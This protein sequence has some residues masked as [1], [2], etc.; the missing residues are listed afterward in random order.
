V[1]R[2]VQHG[3]DPNV[4][5]PKTGRTA[6]HR[7]V[8]KEFDPAQL[9]WLIANGASA[10]IRDRDGVTARARAARKRDR[11]W[12]DALAGSDSRDRTLRSRDGVA[13]RSRPRPTTPC[14]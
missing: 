2:L 4:Q 13:G 14:L 6:L 11:R 1:R 12:L 8:E 7:G 10:D 9:R 5:D 3:A